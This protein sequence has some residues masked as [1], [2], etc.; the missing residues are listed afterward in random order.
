MRADH[1][2][3]SIDPKFPPDQEPFDEGEYQPDADEEQDDKRLNA[4]TR[5]N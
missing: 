2:N 3:L 1:K 4:A 5:V